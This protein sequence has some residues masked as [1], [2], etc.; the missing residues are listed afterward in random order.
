M[1][2]ADACAPQSCIAALRV[3]RIGA[4]GSERIVFSR[5]HRASAMDKAVTYF[6]N[7]VK[8]GELQAKGEVFENVLQAGERSLVRVVEA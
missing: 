5:G 3:L 2:V 1:S 6:Q 7:T 4:F 8:P